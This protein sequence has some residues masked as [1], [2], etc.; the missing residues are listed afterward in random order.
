LISI[1]N[2]LLL[3][4]CPHAD[5][6]LRPISAS[7]FL[8][9]TASR[10]QIKPT[11]TFVAQIPIPIMSSLILQVGSEAFSSL[12]A[13]RTFLTTLGPEEK[14]SAQKQIADQLNSLHQNVGDALVDF[15]D[16]VVRDRSWASFLTTA[17][18]EEDWRPINRVVAEV[19]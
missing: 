10:Q 18:F 6:V 13:A 2:A 4:Y 16:Y 19:R 12:D 11:V 17:Q 1:V 7:S 3:L 14:Y 8:C 5:T 9:K 15:F